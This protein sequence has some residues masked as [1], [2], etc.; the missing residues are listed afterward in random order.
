M[1]EAELSGRVP[2]QN[3]FQGSYGGMNPQMT[4]YNPGMSSGMNPGMNPN[5]N[6]QG[7]GQYPMQGLNPNYPVPSAYGNMPGQNAFSMPAYQQ[8]VT[9]GM[10]GLYGDV[11]TQNFEN[12]S[13]SQGQ[14]VEN[15][16]N[17]MS[18]IF[19]MA[20]DED[21]HLLGEEKKDANTH[22]KILKKAIESKALEE[23]KNERDKKEALRR[24]KNKMK[25]RLAGKNNTS[26]DIYVPRSEYF[27]SRDRLFLE[28]LIMKN[29]KVEGPLGRGVVKDIDKAAYFKDDR[30][31]K[32]DNLAYYDND[33]EYF[34][35]YIK[36]GIYLD[37]IKKLIYSYNIQK[38]EQ[39]TM[40][41]NKNEN[42][43]KNGYIRMDNDI[44]N[45][46]VSRPEDLTPNYYDV[47]N[48]YIS[49]SAFN[50]R[51][52][53]EKFKIYKMKVYLYKVMISLYKIFNREEILANEVK[54]LHR[55]FYTALNQMNI[56]YLIEKISI[57]RRKLEEYYA[58]KNPNDAEK[59]EIENMNI[60]LNESSELL[61]AEKKLLNDKSHALYA[62]WQE[63]KKLR[64]T[65]GFQCTRL[66][67]NVLKFENNIYNTNI[68]DYGFILSNMEIPADD[69]QSLNA[70]DKRKKDLNKLKCK[71]KMYINDIEAF[72]SKEVNITYPFFEA[73]FNS[74]YYI[75]L[76]TRP[77]T[78]HCEVYIN[79][80]VAQKFE[81][82][83]P[84]VFAKTITSAATLYEEVPFGPEEEK[85]EE[86]K[87]EKD[88]DLVDD[89]DAPLLDKSEEEDEK[90]ED[91]EGLDGKKKKIKKRK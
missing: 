27:Y 17:V 48:T 60:F 25:L 29:L 85:E 46:I 28:D 47:F 91:E 14:K 72:E 57:I 10:T 63:L 2:G 41:E 33:E 44:F 54:M 88:D 26:I 77:V 1:A 32:A 8:G 42:F 73:E 15:F 65:Q 9:Q 56:P 34:E 66:K 24:E 52:S 89:E 30:N 76:Y 71:V 79:G 68:V 80:E 75:D 4:G 16:A 38:L 13:Q 84:G 7:M 18:N 53:D 50:G 35:P 19:Q 21:I 70:E 58:L 67:L 40:R 11:G 23:E 82:D 87:E 86:K 64:Q 61:N 20:E 69:K 37:Y 55:D 31:F 49:N 6:P 83:P 22:T 5:F 90:E 51:N 74:L 3:P 59:K 43:K 39:R 36:D 81:V 62:K 78:M 45:D 12:L